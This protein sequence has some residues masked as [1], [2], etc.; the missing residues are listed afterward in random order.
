MGMALIVTL[1][2]IVTVVSIFGGY[3]PKLF[4]EK[5][6]MHPYNGRMLAMLI[7][8]FF[9]LLALFAQPMGQ[10]SAWWPAIIIGLAGAGHQAWSANLFSTIGDMFPKSAIATITGIGGMAGGIS[11]FFIN[12]G[13]GWLFTYSEGVGSAFTFL[14]FEGKEAG[15]MIVFCICA[16]AYLIAWSIMKALVPKYQKIEE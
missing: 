2:A 3:L 15:Y 12:K 1:Y 7:F 10:H 4:V 8:A 14:G 6:G 16:V 11:S 13:A 9:P 5:K